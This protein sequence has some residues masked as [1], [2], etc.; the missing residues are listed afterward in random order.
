MTGSRWTCTRPCGTCC[1]EAG[2]RPCVRH[3]PTGLQ[4]IADDPATRDR[5]TRALGL[6]DSDANRPMGPDR[7]AAL[8]AAVAN[9]QEERLALA[10]DYVSQWRPIGQPPTDPEHALMQAALALVHDAYPKMIGHARPVG[11]Y[12]PVLWV[13]DRPADLPSWLAGG[14]DGIRQISIPQPDLDSRQSMAEKLLPTL[15]PYA[16]AGRPSPGPRP[17]AS[18]SRPRGCP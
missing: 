13:V 8:M 6:R 17:S 16:A 2:T 14:S 5:V 18:P 12:N 3:T 9:S 1:G 10:I 4:I 7:L 15:D 11:L